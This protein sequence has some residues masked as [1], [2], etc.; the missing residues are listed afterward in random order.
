MSTQQATR[1]S[2]KSPEARILRI[3]KD[4]DEP[5][6]MDVLATVC[7][8]F[9][10]TNGTINSE[11]KRNS[12]ETV[13][14][15]LKRKPSV[16][17]PPPLAQSITTVRAKFVELDGGNDDGLLRLGFDGED[18]MSVGRSVAP[19]LFET[20]TITMAKAGADETT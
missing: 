1:F 16:S 4:L 3:L 6:R 19:L 15:P 17:E 2:A 9:V 18:V 20:V 11:A 12:R 7:A 14:G 10:Q 8:A 5:E 13:L